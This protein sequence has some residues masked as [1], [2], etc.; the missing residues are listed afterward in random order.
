MLR[1]GLESIGNVPGQSGWRDKYAIQTHSV[2][3]KIL[4]PPQP[5]VGGL[6][7]ALRLSPR[8]RLRV[9][10]KVF[11]ILD[12]HE[13]NPVASMCDEINLAERRLHSPT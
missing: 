1:R 2:I 13:R 12:L 9:A 8:N 11:A 3:S 7:D 6:G 10:G 5:V 4:L